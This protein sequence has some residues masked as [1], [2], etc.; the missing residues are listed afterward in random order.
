MELLPGP[1]STTRKD[2][3]QLPSGERV[4]IAVATPV[5]STW[6]GPAPIDTFGGK[7]LLDLSGVPGFAELWVLRSLQ[8]AGWDGRWAATYPRRIGGPLLMEDWD[9]RGIK[10]QKN[11]PIDDTAAAADLLRVASVNSGSFAGCWDVFAWKAG[12]R[13]FVDAKRVGKDRIRPTQLRWLESALAAGIGL[14]SFLIAEWKPVRP[15][16]A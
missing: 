5:L 11:M 1:L 2:S 12:S 3:L 10:Y 13:L 9:P 14:D 16:G 8:S 15:D 7:P 6:I 4:E